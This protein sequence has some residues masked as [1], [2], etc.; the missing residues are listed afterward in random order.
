ME[1]FTFL[2]RLDSYSL[3]SLSSL[4]LI[5]VGL[6]IA[7]ANLRPFHYLT[8]IREFAQKQLDR[9]EQRGVP[10]E[11]IKDDE[12]YQILKL[13]ADIPKKANVYKQKN[14][15]KL[16]KLEELEE[17]IDLNWIADYQKHYMFNQDQKRTM[18]ARN[19]SLFFIVAMPVLEFLYLLIGMPPILKQALQVY[20]PKSDFVMVGVIGI[21]ILVSSLYFLYC[22]CWP[23]FYIRKGEEIVSKSTKT[24]NRF[25]RLLEQRV[26]DLI[27]ETKNDAA[28]ITAPK[29]E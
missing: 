4:A 24:L 17:L 27:D 15:E 5:A 9:V 23:I 6:N 21:F 14:L 16:E 18:R 2:S 13:F 11:I 22:I 10:L 19:V 20:L 28:K 25:G 29:P 26:E 7:Y 12:N 1:E 8:Q 3:R